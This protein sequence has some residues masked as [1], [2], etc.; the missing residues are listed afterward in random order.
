MRDLLVSVR[1][2]NRSYATVTKLKVGAFSSGFLV[3]VGNPV[4]YPVPN[5]Y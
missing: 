1:A 2:N 3:S 5:R 4:L